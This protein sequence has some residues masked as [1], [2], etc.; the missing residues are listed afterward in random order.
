MQAQTVKGGM[1]TGPREWTV[2]LRTKPPPAPSHW[3]ATLGRLPRALAAA[4]AEEG[5]GGR[6]AGDPSRHTQLTLPLL[7]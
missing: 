3:A 7:D 4:A 6:G 1:V 5:R 2:A